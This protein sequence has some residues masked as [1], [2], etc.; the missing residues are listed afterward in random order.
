MTIEE[1]SLEEY[2]ALPFK[3]PHVFNTPGF[4]ALNAHKAERLHCLTFSDESRLRYGIILGEREGWLLSP[5]SAPFGGFSYCRAPHLE[6]LDAAAECLLD[7]AR[8]AELRVRISLPPLFY[9]P[10]FVADTAAILSSRSVA[11]HIHLNYHFTLSRFADYERCLARNARK[12]LHHAEGQEWEFVSVWRDD[13]DGLRQ[14]YDVIRRNRE[15]HAYPLS[16]TLD[17]V[18]KTVRVIPADFF[19]LRHGGE[20]VAAA[21]VFHVA[22]GIAQVVYWGDIRVWSPLRTMN[23]LAFRVF[24]HYSRS[25]LR[26]LDIGTSMLGDAPNFGLCDF[27]T[28]VGCEVSPKFVFEL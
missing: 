19:L 2:S 14:A 6:S 8:K 13:E 5:F 27:K 1:V 24:E 7:Y 17:D 3:H 15:E 18:L 28:A 11:T 4:A 16:M 21:Q 22:E 9:E 20:N 25:P 23:M 12:N 10:Q 26:V